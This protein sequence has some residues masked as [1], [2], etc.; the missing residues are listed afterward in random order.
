M[1]R[2]SEGTTAEADLE[3][4]V[5]RHQLAIL[6][7][8]VK[9]PVYR[10]TDRAFLAATSRILPRDLWR[11]FMVRPETLL[12]WHRQLV[13]RKWTKPHRRPGRPAIDLETRNL[14]LR[15]AKENPR[16]G[17]RRIQGELLG[18]GIHLSATSIAS[19]LRRAGLSPAPRKGPTWAQFLR[20]QASGILACDFLTIE[21]VFL[22]TYYVLF[23]IEVKTRSVH[24]AGATTN[25]DGAWVTQQARNVSADLREAGAGPRFLIHDRDTKFTAS[26]DAVFEAEG[27]QIITTPIRAPNANA[28]AERWVGTVRAECLDWILV[29]GRR[30]LERVL[31]EYV[32]HYNDHR[33]HQAMGLH[34]PVDR[35]GGSYLDARHQN[36]IWSRPILGD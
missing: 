22:K 34:P 28:H 8:Q 6:R 7:R 11:S 5:L 12:Q 29:R 9:R 20:S 25:P 32:T 26:Y 27:A 18:L 21:T 15:L 17:Y 30:H 33:P 35:G 13:A 14:V 4:V 2:S 3:I 36:A 23:F 19:I 1:F 10:R 24:V 31:R 16:W